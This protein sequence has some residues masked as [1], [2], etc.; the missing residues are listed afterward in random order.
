VGTRERVA[1]QPDVVG[2]RKAIADAARR[3]H[4]DARELELGVRAGA[5]IGEVRVGFENSVTRSGRS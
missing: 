4:H 5:R 1:L 3:L 2:E